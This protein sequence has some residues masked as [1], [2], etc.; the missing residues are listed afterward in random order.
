MCSILKITYCYVEV[1]DLIYDIVILL[2]AYI[3]LN[4]INYSYLILNYTLNLFS[5][6]LSL[7]LRLNRR[8]NKLVYLKVY[9]II[10][11]EMYVIS[12]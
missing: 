1:L 11:L 6:I 8:C 10:K 2:R 5:N 9:S 4:I 3:I 7:L 12:S